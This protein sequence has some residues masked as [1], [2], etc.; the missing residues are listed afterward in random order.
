MFGGEYIHTVR[1]M[2]LITFACSPQWPGTWAIDD[3]A[4]EVLYDMATITTRQRAAIV[5]R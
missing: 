4:Y 5:A 3:A 2:L 1:I